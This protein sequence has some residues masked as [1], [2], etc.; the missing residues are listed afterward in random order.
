[1]MEL[2]KVEN[3][4]YLGS[5]VNSTDKDIKTRI[6]QVFQALNKINCIWDSNKR[7]EIKVMFFVAAVESVF[8]YG[9][10][11]WTVTQR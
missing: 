10:E 5:W 9:C 6:V 11:R 1:M 3:F 7:E 8:L 2:E 4:K